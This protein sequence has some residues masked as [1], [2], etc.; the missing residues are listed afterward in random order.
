MELYYGRSSGVHRFSGDCG[1]IHDVCTTK[2]NPHMFFS[3]K[4]PAEQET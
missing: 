4:N 2:N 1:F 3:S